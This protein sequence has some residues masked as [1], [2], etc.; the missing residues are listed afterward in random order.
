[1]DEVM[2][3]G[4]PIY[5]DCRHYN[6]S[7]AQTKDPLPRGRPNRFFVTNVMDATDRMFVT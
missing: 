1:M 2:M 3:F 6:S 4:R 5:L 7:N